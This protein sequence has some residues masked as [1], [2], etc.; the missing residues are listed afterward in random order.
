MNYRYQISSIFIGSSDIG[1]Q[2]IYLLYLIWSRNVSAIKGAESIF[3]AALRKHGRQN[4]F[5]PELTDAE[6]DVLVDNTWK[7]WR[8]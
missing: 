1:Y 6:I 2:F 4:R 8:F 5:G 3:F 7:N